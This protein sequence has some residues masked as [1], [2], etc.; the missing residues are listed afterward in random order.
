MW[1]EKFC[2]IQNLWTLSFRIWYS[3]FSD[4]ARLLSKLDFSQ[5]R[6]KIHINMLK[7]WSFMRISIIT[8][9]SY[10][11]IIFILGISV[12]NYVEQGI[13][14]KN[15]FFIKNSPVVPLKSFFRK[16]CLYTP[17]GS[18]FRKKILFFEYILFDVVFHADS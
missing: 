7:L 2:F 18:I 9:Y 10:N 16:F 17:P 6:C 14:C 12:K 5:Y 8:S 15:K 3:P 4:Y 13:F 11:K 1:K